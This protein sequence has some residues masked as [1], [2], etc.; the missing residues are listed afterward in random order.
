MKC[1]R[2]RAL[3]STMY[4]VQ[5]TARV[6]VSAALNSAAT[7]R[8]QLNLLLIAVPKKSSCL[9][10]LA[11]WS[12]HWLTV[13]HCWSESWLRVKLWNSAIYCVVPKNSSRKLKTTLMWVPAVLTQIIS[14]AKAANVICPA[15][16]LLGGSELSFS[17]AS[18]LPKITKSQFCWTVG[19]TSR[20]GS[21]SSATAYL[22]VQGSIF[23]S[24]NYAC[25]PPLSENI[26][27][28]LATGHFDSYRNPFALIFP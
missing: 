17:A 21:L 20:L 10:S 8:P 15:L 3:Y 9:K 27:V 18:T 12:C 26:F 24:K 1:L 4:T 2:I 22:T 23:W 7:S 5:S 13:V 11:D 19:D 28:P 16:Q 6:S 14:Q 25:F